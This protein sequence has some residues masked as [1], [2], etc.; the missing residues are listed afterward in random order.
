MPPKPTIPSPCINRC[1]RH[2]HFAW[3]AGCGRTADEIRRW[4]ALDDPARRKVLERC[5]QR[6]LQEQRAGG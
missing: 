2:A 1:D 4:N 3:C 6:R 5:R